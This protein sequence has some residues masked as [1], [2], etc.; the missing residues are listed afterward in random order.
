M[1]DDLQGRA[2]PEVA[3]HLVDGGQLR[4]LSSREL[5]EGRTVVV[6]GLPGAFTPTCSNRHVPRFEELA[7]ALEAAGVDEIV[8]IAVNDPWVMAA[9]A[10]EQDAPH[11]RFIPDTDAAFT[12]G[13]GM[14]K[15][16]PVLGPR[17]RRYSMLMRDN[18]VEKAFVEPDVEGDPY[19][20]S[21]ADTLLR[22][23]DPQASAL[24]PIAVFA[25]RGCPFC[26]RALRLLR[27]RELAC[28]VIWVG[29]GGPSM[30]AV[31]AISGAST[32]PQVFAG[33][34]LIGGSEALQR[35]LDSSRREPAHAA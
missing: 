15:H 4:E 33:G 11:V 19:Q 28:E 9:W 26:E 25:R 16:T 20:V 35:H 8:C 21:D 29:E 2:L 32:V 23:L 18:V 22:Y 1:A 12:R 5:F 3:F 7:P 27:D 30:Q 13:L 31:L 17:S 6:F 34:R 24:Q 10:R 14:L